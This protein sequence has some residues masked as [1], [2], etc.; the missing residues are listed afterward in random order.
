VDKGRGGIIMNEP[1]FA[2]NKD[3]KLEE[4]DRKL[5]LLYEE[6]LWLQRR[7]DDKRLDEREEQ[8]KREE[9]EVFRRR[10]D[11]MIERTMNR[12]HYEEKMTYFKKGY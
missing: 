7:L 2:E 6:M 3:T 11:I 1:I 4:M 5:N 9:E 10:E 8:L 12:N